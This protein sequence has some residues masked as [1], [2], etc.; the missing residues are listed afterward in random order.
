MADHSV[1]A[2]H[3]RDA[4]IA[5]ERPLSP[6]AYLTTFHRLQDR[7]TA[8]FRRLAALDRWPR[9]DDDRWQ[10]AYRETLGEILLLDAAATGVR[11][12]PCLESVH[13]A[14][15]QAVRSFTATATLVLHELTR[16]GS[17]E[18]EEAVDS[19]RAGIRLME[20][21]NELLSRTSCL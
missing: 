11:P 13:E 21:A 4:A 15:L 14:Y 9:P 2:M 1:S 7:Y 6:A 19:M 18:L 12:P 17:T 5:V 16:T 10:A 8:A 20:R 3:G